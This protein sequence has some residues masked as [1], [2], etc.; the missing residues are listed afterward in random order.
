MNLGTCE[1]FNFGRMLS[2]SAEKGWSVGQA[3]SIRLSGLSSY[4][5]QHSDFELVANRVGQGKVD[6]LRP[7]LQH[8]APSNSISSRFGYGEQPLHT[9]GAHL[10][11]VPDIVLLWSKNPSSVPTRMWRPRT[12]PFDEA[13]GMFAVRSGR[14]V[15]LASAYGLDGRLR[16]DPSCMSPVDHFA[17]KLVQRFS[18]PPPEEVTEFRW[19]RPNLVLLLRNRMI[20]H[21]RSHVTDDQSSREIQRVMLR[22]CQR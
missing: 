14:E 2:E 11:N 20:L 4:L 22:K 12:V 3:S 18:A 10:R 6:T 21:G 7:M 15:W 9:D 19:D 5:A 8:E 1:S 17:T 13:R 16:F